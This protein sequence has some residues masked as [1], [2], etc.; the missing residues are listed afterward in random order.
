[1]HNDVVD[2]YQTG[3]SIGWTWGY[4]RSDAHD[5]DIGFNH[6]SRIGQGVMSDMGGIYT[7]GVQPG[8]VVHDNHVHDIQ[9][10]GYGGWG[11]YTDEGS[12][13]IVIER[14]LVHHTRTGGFFQHTGRDN[15]I[16]NNIFA[17][18]TEAQ[19]E[20]TDPEPHLAFSFTRNIVYWDNASPLMAGC[21]SASPPCAINF[22]FDHN[23]Y[24]N[25]AS[26]PIVFPGGVAFELWRATGQDVHSRVDDPRFVD[27]ARGDFRLRPDSP[28]PLAGFEP[29]E[30]ISA[31]RLESDTA[32]DDLPD[33]PA[34]FS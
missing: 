33:V 29:F 5:N 15:V 20:G 34:A 13:G 19:L 17:F 11:L 28:A 22:R 18:A 32:G 16:R 25:A 10:F 8:T 3:I 12:S 21:H 24:W 4:G 14:N 2:F 27:A 6:V 23:I 7:L 30:A 26:K 1:M 9:S 31:G